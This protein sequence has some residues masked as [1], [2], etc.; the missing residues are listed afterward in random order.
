MQL[1]LHVWAQFC[2]LVCF[3]LRGT[4][5]PRTA[6]H[7][8]LR[9][10]KVFVNRVPPH[11]SSPLRQKITATAIKSNMH[12]SHRCAATQLAIAIAFNR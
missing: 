1:C 5:R 6:R 12:S 4:A 9:K 8:L 11:G 7:P 3:F 10:Q 2:V